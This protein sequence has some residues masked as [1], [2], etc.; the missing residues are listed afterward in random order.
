M[1]RGLGSAWRDLLGAS[2]PRRL[3]E[4]FRHESVWGLALVVAFLSGAVRSAARADFSAAFGEILTPA[5]WEPA[6]PHCSEAEADAD[7]R[8]LM[9]PDGWG[10]R[11]AADG[12]SW[13]GSVCS[14]LLVPADWVPGP[15][16][17]RTQKI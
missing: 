14:E 13:K 11:G 17:K 6:L 5:D 7:A 8:E 16:S 3:G 1:D 2:R 4:S 9:T 10:D 15:H 12:P